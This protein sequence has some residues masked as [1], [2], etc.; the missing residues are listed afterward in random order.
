MTTSAT[1]ADKTPT[2][3]PP[4]YAAIK[5]RQQ[6]TWASGDFGIIGVTLQIVGESL[7]EAVDLR[8]GAR[9][10]DAAAGNG[11][12]SLAAARRFAEVTA[13]DF[14]PELLEN[15][16]RRADADRLAITWKTG[17]VEALPFADGSFD[18]VLSSFGVQFAPDQ[19]KVA[20]ELLRV[21]RTGGRIGLA[22]WTPSGFIGQL[23]GV[24]ARHVPPPAGVE[25]PARWGMPTHLTEWFHQK[26]SRIHVDPK[27]FVFRYKSPEHWLEV[28]RAWY[29]PV[30]KAFGAVDEGGKGALAADILALIARFNQSGDR[31]MVVPAE[32][33]E[34]TID[35]R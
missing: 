13:V 14:V 22:N 18:Y 16:R 21:T 8:A 3:A 31:T 32:Y 27:M 35:R 29:G 7:C 5:V 6:A 4:D 34:V 10:L 11:N 28:F 17:D 2:P 15:G 9:V 24:I 1:V 26:A 23:F 12:T 19:A 20:A 30:L 33:V 25:S